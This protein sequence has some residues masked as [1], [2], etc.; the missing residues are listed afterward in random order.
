MRSEKYDRNVHVEDLK[1][2]FRKRGYPD[3]VIKEQFEKNV[4]LTPSAENNS[5]KVNGVSLVVTY[6]PAFKDFR[7]NPQL[8]YADEQVKEVFSSAPFVSFK[9][10]RNLKSYLIRSKIYPLERKGGSE[11]FKSKRCFVCLNASETDIFQSLQTKEHYKINHQL[12]CND[13]C[14]I[15]L[16]SCKVCGLQYVGSTTDK[17]RIRSNNCEEN[18][19]KAKRG[20]E[21]MQPLVFEHSSSNHNNIFLEDCSITHIDK[22][23]VADRLIVSFGQKYLN[24]CN[25]FCIFRGKGV[26]I[27]KYILLT[28]FISS[29]C[30][31][32]L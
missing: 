26:N 6:N 19:R 8:L 20:E 4:R 3:N 16:L 17:F 15:Y 28:Y 13:T 21:N 25:I 9:S 11:K 32:C 1:I 10:T 30:Y 29:I 24:S 14:L 5:K 27:V 22:T 12:N 2:W 7:K 23:D 31:L 18:N